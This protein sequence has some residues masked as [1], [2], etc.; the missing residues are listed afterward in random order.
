LTNGFDD[1]QYVKI[2][3]A[4]MRSFFKEIITSQQVGT[5]KPSPLFFEYA[6][7]RAGIQ[8][9]EALM[10]GDHVEADVRGALKAGIPAIHYNPF[11]IETD[12]PHEI[13]HLNELRGL[14]K[15]R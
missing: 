13:Q 11:S 10:I 7:K 5:K 4:G 9:E 1:I 8:A 3:G 14:L 6:L 2:E 12:L 15:N